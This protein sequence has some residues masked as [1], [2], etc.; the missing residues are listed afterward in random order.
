MPKA[1]RTSSDGLRRELN[2]FG[3]VSLIVGIVIG[4]GIF[5][6]VNRVAA[7]AGSP[8]LVVLVWVLGG[9]L[10]VIGALTYAELGTMFPRAGGE[11]VFL[12]E[13]LGGFWAFLSGWTA[14][15]INL[16]GSAAALAVVFAAQLDALKPAGFGAFVLVDAWIAGYHLVIEGV[17]VTAAATILLL[18]IVNYFGIRLGG[19]VQ[20]T[21]TVL[22]YTL[23]VGLAA[24]ALFYFGDSP[25][26]DVGFFEDARYSYHEG[27]GGTGPMVV[28]DG[29]DLGQFLG[30]AM[31]AALFAYDGW[32][33]VVR[34][35]S[36]L[37]DPARN[38]PKAMLLGLGSVAV[39]YILVSFGYLQVLG[40]A[41]FA[42]SP[43]T[44]A[45]DAA[46]VLFGGPGQAIVASMILVSVAGSL[47][48]ITISG[49][50]VYYAMSR[51]GVFPTMFSKVNRHAV[52][53]RAI[54]VQAGLSVL[55]LFFFDFESLTDNVVFISFI[56]YAMAAV[57]L[58][59]LRKTRP[60]LERPYKV[61]G[62]PVVPLLFI[63]T[64]L[65][66]VG[67]LLW[68][69]VTTFSANNFSR[70]AG[71]AVVAAGVPVY[72][73]YRKHRGPVSTS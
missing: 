51:D 28:H 64:S 55:F 18:A 43:K 54:W 3:A 30:L 58:M 32:T 8:A 60:D 66:F 5:L 71:L 7:G 22:K 46:H 21:L 39:L 48:G 20:K 37:R 62:Y 19:N 65:A 56:F 26:P 23:I 52:P 15:T 42:Q 38:L 35:G 24:A 50:R 61:P 17:K 68:Q 47:N 33:N 27:G 57:G 41:G 70:L 69:Q 34:V 4:S 2:L 11:Y 12:R 40:F 13:G 9:A 36:E 29:F 16:A 6:G 31:V 45:S 63:A 49:P 72:F 53:A 59:V 25:T 1:V 67:Y 14:F 73:W 44:V 10:T